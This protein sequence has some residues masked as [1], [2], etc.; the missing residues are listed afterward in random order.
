MYIVVGQ[1]GALEL[2]MTERLYLE[3]ER[4]LWITLLSLIALILGIFAC[5]ICYFE[6]RL[7]MR[8]I[9]PIRKLSD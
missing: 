4:G 3:I 7:S 1:A 5:F 6:K 8:V 9:D 2:K